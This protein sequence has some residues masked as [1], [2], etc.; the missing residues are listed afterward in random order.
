MSLSLATQIS[1]PARPTVQ[2]LRTVA[3]IAIDILYNKHGY[4]CYVVS[5]LACN[6]WGA[7]KVPSDVDICFMPNSESDDAEH[8]KELLVDADS[9]FFLNSPKD[10]SAPHYVLYLHLGGEMHCKVDVTVS[11]LFEIAQ[12]QVEMVDG[13]RVMP[14]V[15]LIMAKLKAWNDHRDASNER[16]RF[17]QWNDVDHIKNL[18]RI[19][20]GRELRMKG[21]MKAWP[22]TVPKGLLNASKKRTQTFISSFPILSTIDDAKAVGLLGREWMNV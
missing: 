2:E 13:I 18:L 20:A 7:N 21:W 22:D 19:A 11:T 1:T 9:R 12:H 16:M 10:P 6:L 14:L 4:N 3:R 8:M 5:D 17:K 15:P